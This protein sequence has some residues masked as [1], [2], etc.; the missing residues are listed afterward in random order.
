VFGHIYVIRRFFKKTSLV[1]NPL[2][3]IKPDFA[4]DQRRGLD[5]ELRS[6]PRCGQVAFLMETIGT[7]G[8]TVEA[9]VTLVT[10]FLKFA[11]SGTAGRRCQ[12]VQPPLRPLQ[13]L[14]K[15]PLS[16]KWAEQ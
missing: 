1:I 12:P 15:D 14:L 5:P 16:L 2:D 8:L 7:D 11:G 4:V 3:W 13:P 10:P 6:S 9:I